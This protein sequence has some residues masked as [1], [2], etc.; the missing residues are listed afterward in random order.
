V[1]EWLRPGG[2]AVI[3]VWATGDGPLSEEAE[4]HVYDVCSSRPASK[5]TTAATGRRKSAGLGRSHGTTRSIRECTGSRG[6]SVAND[7]PSGI[8]TWPS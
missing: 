4:R 7:S 3:C 8:I 6:S 2:R 1:G 5:S